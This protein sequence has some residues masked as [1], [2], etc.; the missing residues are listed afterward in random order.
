MS[1]NPGACHLFGTELAAGILLV[2]VFGLLIVVLVASSVPL[3]AGCGRPETAALLSNDCSRVPLGLFGSVCAVE[4]SISVRTEFT[5]GGCSTFAL[6][7]KTS[8][9]SS[10]IASLA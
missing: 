10:G 5:S 4:R 9:V 2:Q 3:N 6:S 7:G 1:L 8:R